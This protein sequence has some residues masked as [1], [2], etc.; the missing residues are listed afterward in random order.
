MKA[1]SLGT[2]SSSLTGMR[3]KSSSG[4]A[5]APSSSVRPEMNLWNRFWRN[6]TKTETETK[7]LEKHMLELKQALSKTQDIAE[8][9]AESAAQ[10]RA[11]C[12]HTQQLFKQLEKTINEGKKR[13]ALETGENLLKVT[14]GSLS[15]KY[16]GTT[17]LYTTLTNPEKREEVSNDAQKFFGE[18]KETAKQVVYNAHENTKQV[19]HKAQE[20]TKQVGES[21]LKEMAKQPSTPFGDNKM[22]CIKMRQHLGHDRMPWASVS[23]NVYIPDRPPASG[24]YQFYLTCPAALLAVGSYLVFNVVSK[25]S[26]YK[27]LRNNNLVDNSLKHTKNKNQGTQNHE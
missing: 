4:A 11:E 8:K 16:D 19:V 18:V 9:A 10:A 12:L 27:T 26:R 24:P 15:E 17:K 25:N 6:L 22:M 2:A 7:N 20:N 3:V 14:T 21:F 23:P 5:R 1:E 13:P